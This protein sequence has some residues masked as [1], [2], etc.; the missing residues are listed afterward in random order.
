MVAIGSFERRILLLYI[1]IRE[2]Q[3]HGETRPL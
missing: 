2:D 3:R 1:T